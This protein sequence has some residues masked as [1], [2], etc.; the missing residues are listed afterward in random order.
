MDVLGSFVFVHSTL[1]F[2]PVY[3]KAINVNNVDELNKN[4]KEKVDQV[5]FQPCP[6]ST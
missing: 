4:A 3:L 5:G 1:F 6:I 2:V